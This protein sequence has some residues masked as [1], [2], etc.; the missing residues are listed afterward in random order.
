MDNRLQGYRLHT[1]DSPG[2]WPPLACS[3][4]SA[5]ATTLLKFLVPR[6]NF[7][8]VS[9]SVLLGPKHPLYHHNWLIFGR[10]Q[11]TERFLIPCPRYVSLRLPP[12]SETCKYTMVPITQT[13]L[14]RFSTYWYVVSV[15]VVELL[16]SEIPEEL[17]N[18]PVFHNWCSESTTWFLHGLLSFETLENS[19]KEYVITTM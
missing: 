17:M 16:S 5:R 9:G 19:M 3:F 12:S 13:N 8:S 1:L 14:E 6:I 7:M 15:L 10:F 11:D 4:R 2:W 18:Y